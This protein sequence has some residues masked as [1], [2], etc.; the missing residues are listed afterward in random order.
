MTRNFIKGYHLHINCRESHLSSSH[1]R[2]L[3]RV[4]QENLLKLFDQLSQVTE[5]PNFQ[6]YVLD[7]QEEVQIWVR[8]WNHQLLDT[9]LLSNDTFSVELI[10]VSEESLNTLDSQSNPQPTSEEE[11]FEGLFLHTIFNKLENLMSGR[12]ECTLLLTRMLSIVMQCPHPLLHSYLLDQTLVLSNMTRKPLHIIAHAVNNGN[13]RAV[14]LLQF[15][16]R[17]DEARLRWEGNYVGNPESVDL[18]QFFIN[19]VIIEEFIKE[20]CAIAECKSRLASMAQTVYVSRTP[21]KL[22]STISKSVRITNK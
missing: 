7:S 4:N 13:R 22:A 20:L 16:V 2:H 15:D 21:R 5:S 8:E 10:S 11:F 14:R 19:S 12:P 1:I 17:R 3:A 9:D 18:E 6:S